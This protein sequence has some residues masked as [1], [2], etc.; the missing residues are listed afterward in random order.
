MKFRFKYIAILAIAIQ[1]YLPLQSLIATPSLLSN[2][3]NLTDETLMIVT[4]FEKEGILNS[5]N[6]EK[7]RN[8]CAALSKGFLVDFSALS[9]EIENIKTYTQHNPY[10]YFPIVS[11]KFSPSTYTA[12]G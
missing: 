5:L 2:P 7:F 9:P 10:F 6:L 8:T 4:G 1:L 12:E 3:A 11:Y